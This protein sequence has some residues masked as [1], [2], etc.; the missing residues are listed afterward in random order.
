M[1]ILQSLPEINN[2]ETSVAEYV[3]EEMISLLEKGNILYFPH[4]A[5]PLT[6][7]ELPFLSPFYADPRV[8]NIS[9]LPGKNKLLG[10]QK[11]TESERTLMKTLLDRYANYALRLMCAL[12]PRYEGTL[13][14][15][16]TS[17]RPIQISGRST[18][19]RKDDK[20]LHIDAFPSAPNQGN[21]ILRIFTNINP[22]GE[23]RVWRTGAPFEE[24]VQHFLPRLAK[25][26]PGELKLVRALRITKSERTLYDHYMLQL[27]DYMKGDLTY[28]KTVAQQELRFPPG[29]SWIVQ[30]DHV[31][32][33]AMSGQ[34][35]LEQTFYL[36][37]NAMQNPVHSPLRV[38][39]KYL[40]KTLV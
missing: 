3:Q 14:L 40:Q 39:E 6:A 31:S 7:Q 29:S 26:W 30:T 16:R 32:H 28:Q 22:H 18:S 17:F 34:H 24:V 37:I 9:F 36:P 2:W 21:R 15:A 35:V 27:H 13:T 38:L 25:P 19:Y 23:D 20:R 1:N 33:A 12:F 11:V 8:K 4:L 10:V 5:F